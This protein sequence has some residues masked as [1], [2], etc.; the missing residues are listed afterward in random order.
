MLVLCSVPTSALWPGEG[1]V[2]K[3]GQPTALYLGSTRAQLST[4][5]QLLLP[6]SPLT[7]ALKYMF[8]CSNYFPTLRYLNLILYNLALEDTQGDSVLCS[9]GYNSSEEG[10]FSEDRVRMG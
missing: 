8:R 6:C 7:M 10:P 9:G 2:R 3:Q 1:Q 5:Q 4:G